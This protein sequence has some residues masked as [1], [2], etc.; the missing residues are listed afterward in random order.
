MRWSV[1]LP[2]HNRPETLQ[3]AIESV[4]AQDDPDFELLVVGDGCTDHTG[5]VVASFADDRIRWFDLPKSP[6]FGYANRNVALREARGEWIAYQTHD[7]IWAPDHLSLMASL[8][9]DDV[10]IAYSRP[11]WATPDGWMYPFSFDLRDPINIV[12]FQTENYIPALCFVTRRRAVEAAGW[13][14]EDVESSGDWLLWRRV[15]AVTGSTR[16]AYLSTPTSI[17]F[18]TIRRNFDHPMVV[19][20]QRSAQDWWPED[21]HFGARQGVIEQEI[22]RE[23]LG[24]DP[25]AWW[26]KVR[27]ATETAE[28]YLAGR[29]PIHMQQID[30]LTQKV[31]EL[32]ALL[33][34]QAHQL[35]ES[36]RSVDEIVSSRS[37]RLTEPVRTGAAR[38]RNHMARTRGNGLS[39]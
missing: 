15:L 7:D 34:R 6:G 10:D 22:V 4:L 31:A 39:R 18:R 12:R 28:H 9:S 35:D 8:L 19:Y 17:H 14:P 2:T 20:L 13:W 33:V 5:D 26:T 32:N 29:E 23:L 24:D 3:I 38:I 25:Q 30:Q 36:R 1:L 37:W 16:P 21:L 27:V 11:I